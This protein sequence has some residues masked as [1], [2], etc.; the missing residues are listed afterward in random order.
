M[1]PETC[2]G[3]HKEVKRDI[4]RSSH[5]PIVEGKV[6]CSDCHNPHRATSANALKGAKG[7]D[8]QFS[9]V[10]PAIDQQTNGA[11]DGHFPAAEDG[12]FL[13]N[14]DERKNLDLY[15]EAQLLAIGSR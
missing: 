5:H 15:L 10:L 6:K 4:S 3:C 7:I 2:T 1:D 12:V 13:E 11:L 14:D 9:S 8:N